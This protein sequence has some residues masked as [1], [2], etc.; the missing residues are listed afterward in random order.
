[1]S[2][3]TVRVLSGAPDDAELA[4]LLTVLAH[5]AAS[6]PGRGP[7]PGAAVSGWGARGSADAVPP[8]HPAAWRLSGLPH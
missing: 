8:R 5:L 3:R 2:E 6:G 1:M 4:A 7:G